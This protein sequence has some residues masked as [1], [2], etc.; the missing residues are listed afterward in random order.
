MWTCGRPSPRRFKSK[1]VSIRAAGT[2]ACSRLPGH[3]ELEQEFVEPAAGSAAPVLQVG[4]RSVAGGGL[5]PGGQD[6]IAGPAR[7]AHAFG[8]G[9]PPHGESLLGALGHAVVIRL[10]AV[11]PDAQVVL[12]PQREGV[13]VG[14]DVY[15]VR[16]EF[17]ALA[18]RGARGQAVDLVLADGV[19]VAVGRG[20]NGASDALVHLRELRRLNSNLGLNGYLGCRHAST[21]CRGTRRRS[22]NASFSM[23]SMKMALPTSPRRRRTSRMPMAPSTSMSW[24]CQAPIRLTMRWA[25]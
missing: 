5:M 9:V 10:R 3:F 18:A 19:A 14:L 8:A 23:S 21:C 16:A 15:P 4:R 20:V 22:P 7:V 24:L 12:R 1:P 13:A 17:D 6:Q 25:A 2:G 11:R